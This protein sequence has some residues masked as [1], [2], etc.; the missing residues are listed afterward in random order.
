MSYS[1]TWPRNSSSLVS[2]TPLSQWHWLIMLV[3]QRVPFLPPQ[4]SR[5]LALHHSFSIHTHSPP[6]TAMLL[7]WPLSSRSSSKF[8]PVDLTVHLTSP[9]SC[10]I[11]TINKMPP[12]SIYTCCSHGLLQYGRLCIPKKAATKL[13]YMMLFLQ[14]DLDVSSIKWQ[15]LSPLPWFKVD[16]SNWINRLTWKWCCMI[17]N[18]KSWNFIFTWLSWV[19]HSWNSSAFPCGRSNWLPW[20]D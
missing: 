17:F 13:S 12:K 5:A 14:W 8:I 3:F 10:V 9:L 19:C 16:F 7:N 4:S 11:N 15:H 20:S 1:S 6:C 18:G 2:S